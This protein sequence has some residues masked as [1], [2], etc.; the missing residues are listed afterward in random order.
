RRDAPARVELAAG[1]YG[2]TDTGALGPEDSHVEWCA[3]PGAEVRISGGRLV[4]VDPEPVTDEE[5]VNLLPEKARK[6]VVQY[7][8]RKLG[9]ADWGDYLYNFEDAVQRRVANT[10]NQG[11]FTMGSHPPPSGTKSRGRMELFVDDKPLTVAR[12]A[13]GVV[14]H[15]DKLLGKILRKGHGIG[16]DCTDEGWFTSKEPLPAAWG[17]EPDPHVCGCWCRDWAEQH[18]RIDRLDLATGTIE[19]SRPWH[20]YR[21]KAG[22]YFYG[23]NMLSE[24]DEP[25]EWYIHRKSGKLIVWMPEAEAGTRRVELSMAS[26]LF[27]LTG[28]KDVVFRGLVFETCRNSAL[29]MKDCADCRVEDCTIRNVGQHALVVEDGERCG[30]RNCRFYGM[31]G[32]GAWLVD[33]NRETLKRSDHFVEGCDIHDFGRWNRMYRP[34][35]CLSGVGMRAERNRIHDSPHAAILYFGC[36][37]LMRSNEVYRV[38]RGSMDCGA[39]YSGRSWL[40]RGTR[41]EGTYIHD[42]IGLNGAA[43]RTIYLDDSIAQVE[44]VGNRFERCTW[45]VYVGGARECVITNNVFVDCPGALH[46]DKRGTHWQKPHIDGRLK[47]LAE[48][49][50]LGGISCSK[51]PYLEAFPA[52]RDLPGPNP[53]EPVKNVIAN[54]TFI[55]GAARWIAKYAPKSVSDPRWWRAGDVKDEELVKWGVFEG[56]KVDNTGLEVKRAE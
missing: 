51:G 21:Y 28:A 18:Q 27:G 34:G 32:G 6:N 9:V 13:P 31:G 23:F 48:K 56:N 11:E 3:K 37:M 10:W 36:N 7:D 25:G 1:R 44:V 5:V 29:R 40:L 54:N 38:C 4:E 19:L 8:L 20:Q 26:R 33:G 39:F 12:S 41:I 42:I 14:Y 46:V 22:G 30:A 47:E 35:V 17:K 52:V 24:L 45:A 50:S 55:R 53:Y 2:L 15:I 49:G 43:A 16:Y